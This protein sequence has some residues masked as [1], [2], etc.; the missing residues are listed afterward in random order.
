MGGTSMGA[1]IAAQVAMGWSPERLGSINRRVWV[2]IRPHKMYTIP[3]FS[4]ISTRGSD[5]VGEM[6]YGSTEI[7]EH[8]PEV[9]GVGPVAG[10]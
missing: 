7:E 2:K 4:I 6:L 8:P 3:L 10:R 1:S 9:C 5:R